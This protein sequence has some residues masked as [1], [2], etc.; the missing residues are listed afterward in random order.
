M[1]TWTEECCGEAAATHSCA[2][3]EHWAGG[4]LAHSCCC[5][6]RSKHHVHCPRYSYNADT[7]TN[8]EGSCW[9]HATNRWKR[10]TAHGERSK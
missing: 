7:N 4:S 1:E 3:V 9:P 2:D 10:C 6:R 8:G 5:Q